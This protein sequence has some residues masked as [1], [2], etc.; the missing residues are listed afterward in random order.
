MGTI[1]LPYTFVAGQTPTATN[2]NANPTTI[3][4]L[5]NGQIDKANVDS[6]SSDGIVTMDETQTI[7]GAKTF[8]GAVINTG[9]VTIKDTDNAAG[10]I[11]TNLTLEWDPGDGEQMTDNSSGVGID[12]KMPDASDNQTVFASL[13][14]LCLDDS[15][16]SEDGEFSFKTVVNASEAEVLTLSGVAATFTV[17]VTVGVDGTGHDVTFFGDTAGK[18]ALWDQSEDTLQLNDNTNLTFGTGADADIF[19]DGTDL[20][21]SPAVVGSGDIVVNG[22]SMEFADSE[23]VTFGTG[24]DATIQYDGTNLVISPA[25]VG[26]GDVSISGGG[27]KLADSESLTLGTGDDATIQF[28][29]TNTVYNTAGYHSFTGGDLHVANGQGLVVGHTAQLAVD[30]TPETQ[31]LGSAVQ[32]AS[33]LMADFQATTNS[34]V[35]AMLKSRNGTIGS[36]TIVQ[37]G[38]QIGTWIGY[39]DDGTDYESKAAQILMSV[40]GTPGANDTP[41]RIT[42]L[43]TA[44]GAAGTTERMRIDSTGAVTKPTNPCFS[45]FSAT[46]S[47]VTGDGTTYTMTYTTEIFDRGGDFSSATFTAPVTGIYQLTILLN[48]SGLTSSHTDTRITLVTSNRSYNLMIEDAVSSDVAGFLRTTFTILADMDASDTATVTVQTSNGTKVVDIDT[49]NGFM[50]HLVG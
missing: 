42:F 29:A 22:A 48:I 47:N 10:S 15:A 50:G 46:Q 38:D 23:G 26:S 18:Q 45:A 1:T 7:S 30:F 43:T 2:W 36:N 17:P 19:Y 39:V 49:G 44:D 32:D 20:N 28:D 6:S 12:F 8:S 5:L 9:G 35:L 25:A 14:V 11:Q 21:I 40:D 13:D 3:A 31:I 34:P 33:M 37:D 16:S 24:K 4:T 27:I 41:G